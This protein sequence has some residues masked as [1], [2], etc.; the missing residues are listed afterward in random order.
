MYQWKY[1]QIVL[2][3][4]LK[5]SLLDTS[6]TEDLNLSD[7]LFT[8]TIPSQ[9]GNLMILRKCFNEEKIKNSF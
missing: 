3:L 6:D 8:G 9:I 4:F 1:R 5:T 2:F 7:N